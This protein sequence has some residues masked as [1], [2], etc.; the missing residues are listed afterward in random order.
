MKILLV[1]PNTRYCYNGQANALVP[2]GLLYLAGALRRAGFSEVA[3]VD[4]RVERL[5]RKELA[6]RMK[7]F[8]PDLVG[9]TGLSP[10]SAEM[11][12]VARLAKEVV[13]GCRV[14]FGGPFATSSPE[15]ALACAQVDFAVRGEGEAALCALASALA[16]GA[17]ASAIAGLVSRGPHGPLF[18][19][20]PAMIEDTG[21]IPLPAWDLP[22]LE[23]YFTTWT[24]HTMNPFPVSERSLPLVTSRGCPYS[25]VYCHGIFGKRARLRAAEDVLDELELLVSKYGAEEI[26]I[27]DDIFNLDLDRAKRICDGI[28]ARGLKVSLCFPNG[29]RADRMDEELVLKLKAAGTHLVFYAVESAS[30]RLQRLIKKN[31][32]LDKAAEMIEFTAAQGITVG[33]F[34]ML[35]FPGETR[36]ELLATAAYA[37]R[38]PFHFASFFFV[39]P[40]QGTELFGMAAGR[41]ASGK[42][43]YFRFSDNYSAVSSWLFTLLVDWADYAF[44]LRPRQWPRMLGAVRNKLYVLKVLLRFKLLGGWA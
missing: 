24:R 22:V 6:E 31:L 23:K 32:D 19:P 44:Y 9:V 2:V 11:F 27:I 17:D 1:Q 14:V 10:D 41:A 30:P 18:G 13:P 36:A 38:L 16:S 40:R 28:V 12:T 42:G 25:C 37:R 29:L 4:A 7:V 35:G 15:E 39:T 3:L 21:S 26:E 43:N 8:A 20:P 5:N 33:G 34:F